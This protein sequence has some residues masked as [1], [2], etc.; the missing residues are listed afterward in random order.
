MFRR[1]KCSSPSASTSAAL[2]Y[3]FSRSLSNCAHPTI[4]A[5]SRSFRGS[6]VSPRAAWPAGPSVARSQTRLDPLFGVCWCQKLLE[7]N[8]V[9]ERQKREREKERARWEKKKTR[10][11]L[12]DCLRKW[13]TS[14]LHLLAT[15]QE[16]LGPVPSDLESVLAPSH[17]FEREE[18]IDIRLSSS[19]SSKTREREK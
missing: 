3:A 4:S 17:R 2:R 15:A 10:L 19:F 14:Q 5:L 1:T 6:I 9:R 18:E 11:R 7:K 8:K 13:I 16:L 12:T